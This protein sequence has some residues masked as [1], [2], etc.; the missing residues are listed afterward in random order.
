LFEQQLVF[1]RKA[2]NRATSG[3]P[4]VF[5]LAHRRSLDQTL[6]ALEKRTGKKLGATVIVDRGMASGFAL[7]DHGA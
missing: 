7:P 1:G 4:L 6:D 3:N 2:G 5:W